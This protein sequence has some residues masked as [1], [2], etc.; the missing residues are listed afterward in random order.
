V[1]L[2]C[3]GPKSADIF[4]R[5]DRA[6]DVNPEAVSLISSPD[7][8][9]TSGGDRLKKNTMRP[10]PRLKSLFSNEMLNPKGLRTLSATSHS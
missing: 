10:D 6:L 9:P 1:W 8:T 3:D 7:P 4:E 2:L 5:E